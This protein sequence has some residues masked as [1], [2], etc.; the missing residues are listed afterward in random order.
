MSCSETTCSALLSPG[1]FGYVF[2]NCASFSLRREKV[3]HCY[4]CV[5]TGIVIM[6]KRPWSPVFGQ[7]W[8]IPWRHSADSGKEWVSMAKCSNDT[9]NRFL[10]ALRDLLNF[11]GGISSKE[12]PARSLT[13]SWLP[14]HIKFG[15]LLSL[16]MSILNSLHWTF[17]TWT[18]LTQPYPVIVPLSVS[19]RS[20]MHIIF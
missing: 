15:H 9:G 17:T 3:Y 12:V 11:G 7:H 13:T 14:D 18:W 20:T 19:G 10:R 4:F 1:W 5:C 16:P 2:N 6:K 8:H